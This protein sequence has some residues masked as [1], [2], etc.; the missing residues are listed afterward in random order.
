MRRAVYPG[1]FDPPTIAHV[2]IAEAALEQCRLDAVDFM[3]NAE[4]LGKA[5][6]RSLP[7]RIEMLEALT[8]ARSWLRVVTTE[9]RYIADIAQGY[10]VLVVGADKWAQ[11]LDPGF[12]ASEA[13][14]DAAVGRLP[15]LAVV[16]RGGL[17]LPPA[18]VVLVIE[19]TMT[20]VS[21][22]AARRGAVE[23]V[24]PEVRPLLDST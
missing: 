1:T 10:D 20:T 13:E 22:T 18:S 17:A 5:S 12:Y 21:S 9:H 24:P 14:R 16:P 2:A 7:A 6:V 15:E 8:A 4:P 23:M 3:L 19:E 11:I